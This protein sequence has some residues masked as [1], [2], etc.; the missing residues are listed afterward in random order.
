[1]KTYYSEI[2]GDFKGIQG[3]ISG[4]VIN[5]Y[6]ITEKSGIEIGSPVLVVISK[7]YNS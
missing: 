7:A 6:I 2:G 5:Q 3:D 4:G 1:M